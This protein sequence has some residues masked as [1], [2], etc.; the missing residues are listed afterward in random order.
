MKRRNFILNSGLAL[1][2]ASS[3]NVFDSRLVQNHNMSISGGS[4][5]SNYYISGNYFD[6][7][8]IIEKTN[9]KRYSLRVN[10]NTE[11]SDKAR[12]GI[13]LAPS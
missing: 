13:K 12:F 2:G 1:A 8:G 9:F 3:V 7:N 5:K 4:E 11:L 6:Q 10:L